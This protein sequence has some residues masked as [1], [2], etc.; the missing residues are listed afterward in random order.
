MMYR[1][2]AAIVCL[3]GCNTAHAAPAQ[4]MQ[5]GSAIMRRVF[6]TLQLPDAP[7][8]YVSGSGLPGPDYWQNRAD[9]AIHARINPSPMC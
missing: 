5:A 2:L 7:N 9:Y 6:D 3:A 4:N 8:R 1:R